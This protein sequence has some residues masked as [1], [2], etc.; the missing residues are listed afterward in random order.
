MATK[1]FNFHHSGSARIDRV[2]A[3]FALALVL[4]VV[5]RVAFN[6]TMPLWFDETFT[7]T[8]ATQPTFAGLV[9]WCLTE[10]TGP[11]FYAPM[12]AWAR[13]FGA[14]DLALRMPA[15]LLS[16]AAPLLLARHGHRDRHVRLLWAG[17]ALLWLPALPFANDARPYAQLFFLACV[18]AMAFQSLLRRPGTGTA[19]AWTSV[20][21]LL[22]LT[23]YTSVIVGVIQGLAYLAVHR[24]RAVAT[25]PALAPFVPAL[26]WI[27]WHWSFMVGVT[28][29]PGSGGASIGPAEMLTIP[30]MIFGVQTI[31]MLVIGVMLAS[32]VS[33]RLRARA[34]TFGGVPDVA[35][36]ATGLLALTCALGLATIH[37][38]F[39]PRYLTPIMPSLLFGMALWARWCLRADPRPVLVAFVVLAAAMA[40]LLA[41]S[42]RNDEPDAR[43][44][45]SFEAASAWLAERR[46]E[47]LVFL[48][49]D[50][51]GDMS[52]DRNVAEIA[53]FSF[54]RS[55]R[56]VAVT[57]AHRRTGGDTSAA[58]LAAAG[59]DQRAGILWIANDHDRPDRV[60]PRIAERDA[61][62]ECRDFGHGHLTV[63][64]CRHKLVAAAPHRPNERRS[65]RFVA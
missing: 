38:G 31:G 59:T 54:R 25:W 44:S 41:S 53:G 45:F 61:S 64:A 58:A 8:I 40:T 12:W 10:L 52:L 60:I 22:L 7:G 57:L 19:L 65:R 4:G 1:A 32:L 39:V 42:L 27:A 30:A 9:R 34:G 46:P 50:Q 17:A 43:H 55:G 37:L 29:A 14:S 24:R 21:A 5:A 26:A 11:G 6:R 28:M 2:R 20:T 36:A 3:G 13:L 35:L 48:W 56:P 47:R 51:M 62:W 33:R 16:I 15:L 18:Q 23:H 63:T 49:T